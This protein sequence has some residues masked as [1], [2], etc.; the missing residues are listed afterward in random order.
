MTEEVLTDEQPKNKAAN[1]RERQR[2]QMDEWMD[3]WMYVRTCICVQVLTL[4]RFKITSSCLNHN[5]HGST[6][7]H[8]SLLNVS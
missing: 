4:F 3:G 8:E 5:I 1:Q 7:I 2:K 6:L